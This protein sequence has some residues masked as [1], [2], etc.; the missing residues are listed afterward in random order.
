MVDYFIVPQDCLHLVKSFK[1]DV[2]TDLVSKH[3]CINQISPNSKLPDHS[4]LTTEIKCNMLEVPQKDTSQATV[5]NCK[6]RYKFPGNTEGYL[7]SE[8]WQQ[9]VVNTITRL[10]T[11]NDNQMEL[12]LTYD[13]LCKDIFEELD[14]IQILWIKIKEKVP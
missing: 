14:P 1:V 5:E 7:Y 13:N 11:I 4:V 6:K 12:D 10:E 9:A 2:V 8:I 3:N